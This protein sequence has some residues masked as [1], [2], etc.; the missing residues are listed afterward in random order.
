[1]DRKEFLQKTLFPGAICACGIGMAS[2][3]RLLGQETPKPE[4][5]NEGFRREWVKTLLKNMDS[6]LDETVRSR[7]MEAC[8]RDCARRGATKMAEPFKGNVDGL[9]AALAGHL[10]KD[11]VRR[12]GGLVTLQYPE[13]Y[14]PMV[15]KIKEKISDTWCVCSKGWVLEMFGIAADKPVEV[16]LVQSIK[17]GDPVCRFEIGV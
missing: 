6:T 16:K 17:R 8:G 4:D 11:N 3:P 10:G 5:P 7:F 2:T 12:E 14:C 9:V 1:M 15:S 13:C